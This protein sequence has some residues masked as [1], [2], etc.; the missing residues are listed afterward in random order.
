MKAGGKAR[1]VCPANI[2]YGAEGRPPVI[3]SGAT[4]IFEIALVDINRK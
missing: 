3:P 1:L 4:L 2:A